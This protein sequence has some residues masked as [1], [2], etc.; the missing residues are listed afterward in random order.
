MSTAFLLSS[1]FRV[2]GLGLILDVSFAI[3]VLRFRSKGLGV[4]VQR[5]W[6]CFFS[7]LRVQD[8]EFGVWGWGV[9]FRV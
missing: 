4:R 6:S 9:E 3:Y 5:L 7:G 2:D 1:R 8:L